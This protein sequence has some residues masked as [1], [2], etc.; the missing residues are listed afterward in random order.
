MKNSSWAG[1]MKRGP[2]G[3]WGL[4]L[5]ILKY[6]LD[7]FL[8]TMVFH[9]TWH[10]LD[11]ILP[12]NL[13]EQDLQFC[14][15]MVVIGLP[16]AWVGVVLTLRRLRDAGLPLYLVVLFFVP[17]VNLV[18]FILLCALPSRELKAAEVQVR[19][20]W[21]DRWMPHSLLGCAGVGAVVPVVLGVA[22]VAL[23]VN[24][25]RNYGL[26]LFVVVPFA[27]GL[28]AVLLYGYRRQPNWGE[29]AGVAAAAVT[30]L[31]LTLVGFAMEGFVCLVMAAP[32]AFPL[33][34]LGGTV[35][36]WIQRTG[37]PTRR[38]PPVIQTMAIALPLLMAGEH[39][40]KPSASLL[41]VRSEVIIDA[42]PERVWANVIA[43]SEL[44]EPREWLFKI[45]IAYPRR[46]ELHGTGVGAIRHCVFSTGPFVEPIEVWD[47]PRLLR[48]GVTQNPPPMEE[49]TPYRTV[50]PPH[51]DGFLA[52]ER[53][54][55]LLVPL[56]DGRTQLEG[57]TWYRHH[58]WPE[59]YWQWWSDYI[60][61]RIHLRVL[62]HIKAQAE[63][64]AMTNQQP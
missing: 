41:E 39:S 13:F 27:V 31:G 59:R 48:F 18:F 4:G 12:G 15:W 17:V 5:L 61:H 24:V 64:I 56:P 30:L 51:L 22:T 54:Q 53:G 6:N 62:N 35:G 23:G 57:T 7:R 19:R 42:P 46:A 9:R 49:W 11:Y 60:I 45:G 1:T 20:H 36:Y 26:G 14:A 34:I 47:E 2:Y 44:P 21:L 50:H 38:T 10:P 52:S 28:I 29:C 16:F 37:D 32:L 3:L 58:M 33:A 25:F 43:F 55:F 40:L 8:A 63:N